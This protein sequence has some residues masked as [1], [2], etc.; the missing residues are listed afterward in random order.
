MNI[1]DV[2]NEKIDEALRSTL[3]AIS[4]E[5]IV[6]A[7]VLVDTNLSLNGKSIKSSPE[8][9]SE[10]PKEF[11]NRQEYRK[12]MISKQ[13]ESLKETM[14][15]VLDQLHSLGLATFGGEM[16]PTFVVQGPAEALVKAFRHI[17]SIKHASLD[18]AVDLSQGKPSVP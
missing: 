13:K 8:E 6:R 18:R 7:I 16:T 9:S 3:S 1:T 12:W 11:S 15:P 10:S 14:Q 4:G 17:E 2:P 5:D